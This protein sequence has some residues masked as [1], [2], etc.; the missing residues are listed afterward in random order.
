MIKY[1]R[2][3]KEVVITP[4]GV[5]GYDIVKGIEYLRLMPQHD[6][7]IY[8]HGIE[9]IGRGLPCREDITISW[10]EWE[11]DKDASAKSCQTCKH[12]EDYQQN[13]PYG[14]C[15]KLD[16]SVDPAIVYD[17]CTYEAKENTD[18]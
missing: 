5:T 10:E 4:H 16:A 13:Y 12:F 1:K 18:V 17:G 2:V 3:K 11:E 14:K 7:D 15:N 8:G 9:N 6:T